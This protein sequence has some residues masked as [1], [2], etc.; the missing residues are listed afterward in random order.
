MFLLNFM[1]TEL[2]KMVQNIM[3]RQKLLLMGK[4]SEKR[5]KD[6]AASYSFDYN[7]HPLTAKELDAFRVQLN[8]QEL[9]CLVELAFHEAAQI[10]KDILHICVPLLKANNPL[11]LS[12]L[13][14]PKV[15]QMA[16]IHQSSEPAVG[17]SDDEAESD[18]D[19]A[20]ESQTEVEDA[21]AN[22]ADVLRKIAV[23]SALSD[24]LKS[25]IKESESSLPGTSMLRCN[26]QSSC[27]STLNNPIRPPDS[28]Q[29]LRNQSMILGENGKV[30]IQLILDSRSQHQSEATRRLE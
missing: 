6:S 24:D 14:A 7:P 3:V 10:C 28:L 23:L 15:T 16:V 17:K 13:G 30:S 12:P 27:S 9:N 19:S 1:Y 4:F 11:P 8:N 25:A 20:N 21:L 18:I 22:S 5:E 26:I 29:G 2:L